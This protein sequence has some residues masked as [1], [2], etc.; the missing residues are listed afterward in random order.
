MKC[1]D[2]PKQFFYFLLSATLDTSL[3]FTERCM[4]IIKPHKT[5]LIKHLVQGFAMNIRNP[6]QPLLPFLQNECNNTSFH[7]H[8]QHKHTCHCSEG[9]RRVVFLGCFSKSYS[10]SAVNGR[11]EYLM[12]NTTVRSFAKQPFR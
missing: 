11:M 12:L 9:R 5:V 3:W 4:L 10:P 7:P 6:T 2:Y 8:T 1:M